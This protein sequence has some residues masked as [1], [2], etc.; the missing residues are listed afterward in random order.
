MAVAGRTSFGVAGVAAIDRFGLAASQLALF[1]TV[2]VG[3]YALAQVPAG[4]VIDRFGP[5]KLLFSGAILMACG[6]VIMA[7]TTSFHVAVAARV[8][9]GLG[10]ATAFLSVMRLLPQWFPLRK[11]PIFAQVTG[12]M[13]QLGQV[14]SA[15]PFLAALGAVGWTAAFLGLGACGVIV[16]VA[17]VAVVRDRPQP[18]P[19]ISQASRVPLRR[20]LAVVVHD[21]VVWQGLFTHW[22]NMVLLTVFSLLW[23]TPLMQLGMGLSVATIGTLLS[24]IAVTSVCSGPIHGLIS[25]RL[26]SRR[27][28]FSFAVAG[29]N[30]AIVLAFFLPTSPPPVGWLFIWVIVLALL[31]PASGFGF[32]SIRESVDNKVVATAT[33]FANMGGFISTMIAGQLVG[34]VL[35]Q[36]PLPH[37]WTEFRIAWGAVI[38]VWAIGMVGFIYSR[39]RV[40]RRG[41]RL[42]TAAEG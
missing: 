7:L 17:A 28:S 30:G 35:D 19:E 22:T 24:V 21:P 33:G 3:V 42:R 29:L 26:G 13:G 27:E 20:A 41:T 39:W 11:A 31:I 23:G 15:V 40:R 6:Q 10:D 2:Q 36:F 1:I 4:I 16:A 18:A 25:A 14:I 12:T 38:G 34:I 37:G 8:L 9:I 5:R 32:D